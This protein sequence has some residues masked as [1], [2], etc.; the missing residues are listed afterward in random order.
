LKKTL[1]IVTVSL[2]AFIFFTSYSHADDKG[3]VTVVWNESSK[4]TSISDNLVWSR[5]SKYAA[6]RAITFLK[7]GL[8]KEIKLLANAGAVAVSKKYVD[9]SPSVYTDWK[10]F[11]PVF[12]QFV[13]V[14]K[15]K[16]GKVV[17]KSEPI[18][19]N[20][21][22]LAAMLVQLNAD[23]CNIAGRPPVNNN[24][25]S[26]SINPVDESKFL[27]ASLRSWI[28]NYSDFEM[29]ESE[30]LKDLL[31]TCLANKF[32]YSITKY[33]VSCPDNS[34]IW[35]ENKDIPLN[36]NYSRFKYQIVI[37]SKRRTAVMTYL[38]RTKIDKAPEAKNTYGSM[39]MFSY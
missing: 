24:L 13:L 12:Q 16:S 33:K 34:K 21:Q 9:T 22:D 1:A 3:Q 30:Y 18:P 28:E 37:D 10:K 6:I 36:Q 8:N 19:K 25:P 20:T 31:A 27:R 23:V 11:V 2:M 26:C 17:G 38:N 29:E 35:A 15:D 32:K 39:L 4:G 14:G 7:A 5:V